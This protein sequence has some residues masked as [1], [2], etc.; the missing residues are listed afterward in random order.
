MAHTG[1]I[2]DT[3]HNKSRLLSSFVIHVMPSAFKAPFLSWIVL[4]GIAFRRESWDR[5]GSQRFLGST[6]ENARLVAAISHRTRGS[7]PQPGCRLSPHG[8]HASLHMGGRF[9]F[10]G[11]CFPHPPGSTKQASEAER[12]SSNLPRG[13]AGLRTADAWAVLL[14]A[15]PFGLLRML[16]LNV[17]LSW[18][19]S[20]PPPPPLQAV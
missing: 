10:K 7:G 5:D 17:R 20:P 13:G 16:P 6:V 9:F 8:S 3:G 15:T 4:G 11:T 19:P 12:V 1:H 18:S 2:P 14:T